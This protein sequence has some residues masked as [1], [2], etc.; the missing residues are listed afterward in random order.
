MV[1]IHSPNLS[2][3]FICMVCVQMKTEVAKF[4]LALKLSTWSVRSQTLSKKKSGVFKMSVVI[5]RAKVMPIIPTS[6]QRMEVQVRI[7]T[8]SQ[9]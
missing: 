2:A 3:L 1:L 5:W 8:G 7:V 4:I 9:T 6:W